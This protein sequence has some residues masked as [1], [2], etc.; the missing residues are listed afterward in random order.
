MSLEKSQAE[1]K[2]CPLFSIA[3]RTVKY[4][5]TEKCMFWSETIDSRHGYCEVK[6]FLK[7]R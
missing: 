1:G 5:L 7:K 4:C 2:V 3:L 6:E